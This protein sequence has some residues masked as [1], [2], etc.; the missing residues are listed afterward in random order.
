MQKVKLIK[1]LD[2]AENLHIGDE[3]DFC[4]TSSGCSFKAKVKIVRVNRK[5]FIGEL[6]SPVNYGSGY[7]YSAGREIKVP[8]P[9]FD[10]P[11]WTWNNCP[12]PDDFRENYLERS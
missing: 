5:S 2:W 10:N 8:K 7:E 6:L 11:N 4:W 1:Y 3:V 9:S 12:L